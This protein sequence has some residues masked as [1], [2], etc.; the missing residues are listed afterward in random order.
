FS[1]FSGAPGR[2]QPVANDKGLFV[3]VDY[4]HTDDA[5]HSVLLSVR[6]F[7]RESQSSGHLWTVFGCGGDRDRGKRPL[8][9]KAAVENSDHVVMTS[10]N[11]RTEDPAAI[12]QDCLKGIS[13][14]DVMTEVYR[15]KGIGR[16]LQSAQEG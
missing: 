1:E 11:P 4:A 12:I 16:A 5:L 14:S 10:D 2:L 6:G 9:A 13:S 8:M 15:R 3:F 7:M